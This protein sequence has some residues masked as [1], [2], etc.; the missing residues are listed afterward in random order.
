M[1][2]KFR[3]HHKAYNRAIQWK[4]STSA[5]RCGHSPFAVEA[6]SGRQRANKFR[7]YRL[8]PCTSL[9]THTRAPYT[10]PFSSLPP[11][12][13]S[14]FCL[15]RISPLPH[16]SGFLLLLRHRRLLPA[17]YPLQRL[18]PS[19]TRSAPTFIHIPSAEEAE[20]NGGGNGQGQA[21]GSRT[22]RLR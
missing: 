20:A 14:Q 6:I 18:A 22:G 12:I 3:A 2:I 8:P 17:P 13:L 4:C 10:N 21:C 19:D 11:F 9:H 5:Q 1:G 7:H 15:L 16:D